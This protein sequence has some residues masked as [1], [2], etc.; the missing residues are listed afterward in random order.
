MCHDYRK[1]DVNFRVSCSQER[2][3]EEAAFN[4]GHERQTGI[5][6]RSSTMSRE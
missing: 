2:D 3:L 6:G 4:T 5:R 1:E